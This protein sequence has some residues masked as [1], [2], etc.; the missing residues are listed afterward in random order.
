MSAPGERMEALRSWIGREEVSRET[1]T[2][3]RVRH[4]CA[5]L[6]LP[7]PVADDEA[8]D[9]GAPAPGL[10]HFCLMT[11]DAPTRAL[12]ADGHP[13][14]GGFLPPVPLPRRMWAGGSVVRTGVIRIGDTVVRRSRIADV[15]AREGRSG[16]LCFV[17]VQHDLTVDGR[18]VVSERQDLVYREAPRPAD[19]PGPRGGSPGGG[20]PGACTGNGCPVSGGSAR[21]SVPV[22]VYRERVELSPVLLFRFSAITFNSHR[23][24]YD[25]AYAREVEG[26]RSLVVHGPLQACLL[27]H[28]AERLR[29]A[30]PTRFDFRSGAPLFDDAPALLQAQ[31]AEGGG[32]SLWTA[33]ENGAPAMTATALWGGTEAL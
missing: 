28:F 13:P 9:A 32:L 33:E 3:D 5:T 15:Q 8:L 23:I 25:L 31:E 20:V 10:I 7:L 18:P 26:Y 30:P 6:D 2:A 1:L 16:P 29:G 21:Q 19:A 22:G 12:S 11:P 17:T 24:H 14:K 27:F 4:Y